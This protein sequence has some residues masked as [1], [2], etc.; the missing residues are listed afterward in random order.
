MSAPRVHARTRPGRPKLRYSLAVLCGD[1]LL[2]RFGLAL[3]LTLGGLRGAAGDEL[4]AEAKRRYEQGSRLFSEGRFVEAAQAFEKAYQLTPRSVLLYDAA[5]AYDK[6][7]VATRAYELY[8]DYYRTTDNLDEQVQIKDRLLELESTVAL[9]TI[10]AQGGARITL[11]GKDLGTTPLLR[12][13]PIGSGLHKIDVALGEL[14]WH[15]EQEFS[16]GL[17]HTVEAELVAPPPPEAEVRPAKRFV[18]VVGLGGIIDI[19]GKNYPP[20]QASLLFGFEYRIVDR[21][22][23]AVDIMAQVPVE[24]AQGWT[25]VA[26]MPGVRLVLIPSAKVPLEIVPSLGLGLSILQIAYGA[27]NT[28]FINHTPQP[29]A[30]A[31]DCVLPALRIHPSINLVYHFLPDWELRGELFGVTADISSPVADPRISFGLSG[32]WRFH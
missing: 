2:L 26:V 31:G 20:S 7:G 27:P 14:R 6:G 32:A 10:K 28:P 22:S 23:V 15:R 3:F 5:R 11:D 12:P 4:L 9:L 29:C 16:V 17:S 25:N 8:Q 21:P 24:V 18:A 19:V 13:V 30:L 1:S